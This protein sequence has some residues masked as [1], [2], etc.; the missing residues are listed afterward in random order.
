MKSHSA[1]TTAENLHS[2]MITHFLL[3]LAQLQCGKSNP[4]GVQKRVISGTTALPGAWPWQVINSSMKPCDRR[5]FFYTDNNEICIPSWFDSL[6]N[7]SSF[8]GPRRH[9]LLSSKI[10][11]R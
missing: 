10:V 8:S 11:W 1:L 4:S 2:Q 7:F 6:I 9:S 5:S 3:I